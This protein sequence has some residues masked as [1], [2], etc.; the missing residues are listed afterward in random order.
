MKQYIKKSN[1]WGWD[2][3][4]KWKGCLF[5]ERMREQEFRC[6]LFSKKEIIAL[7][8]KDALG[9]LIYNS[10]MFPWGQHCGILGKAGPHTCLTGIPVG[11][12]SCPSC[13]TYDTAPCQQLG[14]GCGRGSTCSGPHEAP[15]SSSGSAF[16]AQ[17]LSTSWVTR[18]QLL[19]ILTL[20]QHEKGT[21]RHD[22]EQTGH[23]N[24]TSN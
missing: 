21:Y 15:T 12:S 5:W 23:L 2:A 6:N 11:T 8:R 9:K 17:L 13:P 1:V 3:Y 14:E 19:L 20:S 4:Q 24:N 22:S 10:K 7:Y 16:S 18:T